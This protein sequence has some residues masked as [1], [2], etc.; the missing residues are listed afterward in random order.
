MVNNVDRFNHLLE[1]ISHDNFLDMQGIGNEVPFFICPFNP[2]EALEMES[3][4]KNLLKNLKQK[5]ISVLSIN[6]YDLVIEMMNKE[7]DWDYYNQNES[8]LKKKDLLNELRGLLDVEDYLVPFIEEKMN[9][10]SFKVMFISGIGQVFPYI[11]AHKL[12]NNLQKSA[13][14]HP[15]LMFFPGE[16]SHTTTGG[17]S[18]NLFNKF[19]ADHYYR[20]FNIYEFQV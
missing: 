8:S 10:S 18:L 16:Y 6:L 17:A 14:N 19:S 12:L 11:R 20:A 9:E 7:G 5:E 2:K 13:K 1:V 3:I 4:E 15:T